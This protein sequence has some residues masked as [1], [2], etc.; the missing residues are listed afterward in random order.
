MSRPFPKN[1]PMLQGVF[2]PVFVE[3]DSSDLPVTGE[4]PEALAGTLYRNGP[5]PQFAPRGRF[6]YFGGDG[7]VHA[8]TLANGRAT[9]RNRWVRTP[10]FELE[11]KAGEAL[12]GGFGDPFKSD[13]SVAGADFGVA[14]T[15]IVFHAGKLL[16]LEES[17]LPFEMTRSLDSIGYTTFGGALPATI[18]GRFT[19]HPKIDPANGE[20]VGFSYSGSGIYGTRMSLVIVAATGELVRQ[21]FF[22]APYCS[23]VHD[24]L[25]TRDHAVFPILPLVG[26]MARARRGGPAYAWDP[27][28]PAMLGVVGRRAPI[29][30]L[31]WHPMPACFVF[32]TFNAW[33]DGGQIHCD[34]IKYDR[35]P[36]FPDVEGKTAPPLSTMG[37]PVRWSIDLTGRTDGV[38]ETLLSDA[39]GEF[40]R[41][42]ERR[43]GV[44]YHRAF[45]NTYGPGQSSPLALLNAVAQLDLASGRTAL[46]SVPDGDAL[47]EAVFVPRSAGSPEG[48]GFLLA[49]H[50][51][52]GENRSD[53]LI[54][55]ASDLENGPVARVHLSHRVPAGA[56]G[57]WVPASAS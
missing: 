46:F 29:G 51:I 35:A 50:Y 25:M 33:E 22:E 52:Q 37:A 40:P 16:A 43:S 10:R 9:Y 8:F 3:G 53:L 6:H 57:S 7:M 24:F 47:S 26:D 44:G 23:F 5:N 19:A 31:K 11:R 45:Y 28:K 39:P 21:D 32:H 12:F 36:F 54:L 48:D 38:K 20:L 17:H 2:A 27:S 56:H 14:N 30:S 34:A 49:V 1:E 4:I 13:P 18:E 42:D 41:L 55:D 15:H